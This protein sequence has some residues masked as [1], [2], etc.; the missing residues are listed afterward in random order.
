[1][2]F[3]NFTK[4]FT[5]QQTLTKQYGCFK[6]VHFSKKLGCPSSASPEILAFGSHCSVDFQPIL[7]C[8]VPKFTLKYEDSE[9]IMAGSVNRVVSK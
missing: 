4:F 9:N 6:L 8:F 7:N 5:L 2:F 1:M 3:Y